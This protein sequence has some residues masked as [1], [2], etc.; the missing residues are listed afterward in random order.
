MLLIEY[1]EKNADGLKK[2]QRVNATALESLSCEQ[3]AASVDAL[4]AN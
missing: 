3:I 1:F 4:L 2:E